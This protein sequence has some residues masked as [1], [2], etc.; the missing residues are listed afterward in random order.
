[1]SKV[2]II[3]SEKYIYKSED[4]TDFNVFFRRCGVFILTLY[5]YM[6]IGYFVILNREA[7]LTELFKKY[8]IKFKDL[9]KTFPQN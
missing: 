5:L 9:T 7:Y 1:M 8:T 4:L 6:L 2:G 3:S